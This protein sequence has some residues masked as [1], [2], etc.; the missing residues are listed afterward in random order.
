MEIEL[1]W[2]VI[3]KNL[4]REKVTQASK[5]VRKYLEKI[6]HLLENYNIPVTWGVLGHL[7]LDSCNSKL[8]TPHPEMPRPSYSWMKR[9]WYAY[10]PCSTLMKEPA[11]YGRDIIDKIVSYAQTTALPHDFACHSFSHQLFGD[12]GCSRA[13]AETEI[14]RCVDLMGSIY[15]I[16]PVVF[17]FPRNYQ[18]HL[19]VLQE[20]G[21]IAFRGSIPHI[22]PYQESIRSVL[23]LTQK[24]TSLVID[25][26]S[27]YFA[28]SPPVVNPR[29]EH[30]L[31]NIPASMCFNK[32]PL[33]PLRLVTLRAKRG[34]DRAIKER[35][36]FHLF[37]HLINL[38]EAPD[39]EA[40]IN[41]L[42]EV[43]KYVD[44]RREVLEITTM[45][46]MAEHI[47][48]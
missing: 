31:I 1:A 40:L 5:K 32:K 6:F 12:P 46:K 43:L 23:N 37:M 28:L 7:L 18:G 33:M 38:G 20:N 10:D 42:E 3:D 17:I 48:Q 24:Q 30:D 11:F 13:V 16:R 9:D 25:M 41:D 29:V 34:I 22:V 27:Y 36:V 21:F 14:R 19:D 47:L 39:P 35:K 4:P 45:R 8:G 2:G 44:R 15:G 26:A